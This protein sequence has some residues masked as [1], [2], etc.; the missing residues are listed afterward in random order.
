MFYRLVPQTWRH[1]VYSIKSKKKKKRKGN[2]VVDDM[3]IPAR[4]SSC[5]FVP[6]PVH[7]NCKD[8][9][10]FFCLFWLSMW[11]GRQ[12]VPFECHISVVLSTRR[13]MLRFMKRNFVKQIMYLCTVLYLP[14]VLPIA[15]HTY[16]RYLIFK[17]RN[18]RWRITLLY[19][20]IV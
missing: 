17:K 13:L 18:S 15:F 1:L 2:W 20:I 19:L 9:F 7:R 6:D 5:N 3:T 14:Y 16:K 10:L 12:A 8:F 11:W 4:F